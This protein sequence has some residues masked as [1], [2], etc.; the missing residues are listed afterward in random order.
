LFDVYHRCA[1]PSQLAQIIYAAHRFQ[2]TLLVQIVFCGDDVKRDSGRKLSFGQFVDFLV[3]GM[4]KMF[5][6]Q[7]F[8]HAFQRAVVHQNR[9]QDGLFCF[10]IRR[11]CFRGKVHVRHSI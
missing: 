8:R 5:G 6:I 2:N 11:Q 7:E 4:G 9:G 10:Q 3:R 1:G